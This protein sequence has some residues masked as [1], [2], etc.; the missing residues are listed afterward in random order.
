M[1]MKDKLN[2]EVKHRE[3]YRP[4]APSST[5]EEAKNFFEDLGD[6]PFMLKVCDVLPEYK[7]KLPAITH[8]DGS[9]RLQTVHKET[10]PRYHRLITQLGK[11]TGFPVILNTSFNI[12]GEPIV[13]SPYDAIRCFFST[14]IDCLVIGNFI[15]KK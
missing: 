12:M 5:I 3:A 13:E 7:S 15:I 9:A 8:V 2:S 6:N 4:F 1:E 14:G 11:L 10:N